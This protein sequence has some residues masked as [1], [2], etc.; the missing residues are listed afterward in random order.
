[1]NA[2]ICGIYLLQKFVKI[3][4]TLKQFAWHNLRPLN[5]Y[6]PL[7]NLRRSNNIVCGILLKTNSVVILSYLIGLSLYQ[8]LDGK[9]NKLLMNIY[10]FTFI[11]SHVQVTH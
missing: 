11:Y 3:M 4:E 7:P 8:L 1:M 2:L 6:F 5:K 9:G 10:C